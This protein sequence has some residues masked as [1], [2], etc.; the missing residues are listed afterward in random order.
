MNALRCLAVVA[1]VLAIGSFASCAQILGG[2]FDVGDSEPERVDATSCNVGAGMPCPKSI[3]QCV[4]SGDPDVGYICIVTLLQDRD[5][6]EIE[7]YIEDPDRD[8]SARQGN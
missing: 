6:S 8:D 5:P 1:S 2:P 7:E 3:E 4:D